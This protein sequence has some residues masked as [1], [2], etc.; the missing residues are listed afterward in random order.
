MVF[1]NIAEDESV[2]FDSTRD[3]SRVD[4]AALRQRLTDDG[5]TTMENHRRR[6]CPQKQKAQNNQ[7]DPLSS[8]RLI[9]PSL[10]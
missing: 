1:M 9:L 5:I 7:L 3:H 10:Q 6:Y 8:T 2:S 4:D